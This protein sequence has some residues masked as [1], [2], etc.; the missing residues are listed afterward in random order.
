MYGPVDIVLTHPLNGRLKK[1]S[2]IQRTAELFVIESKLYS[3]VIYAVYIGVERR[4][5]SVDQEGLKK[6]MLDPLL[7]N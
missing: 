4:L 1:Q 7:T 6:G 2:L 5:K 3:D